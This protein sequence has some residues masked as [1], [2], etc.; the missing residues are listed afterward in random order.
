MLFV[1]QRAAGRGGG[2]RLTVVGRNFGALGTRPVARLGGRSCAATRHWAPPAHCS[3]GALDAARGESGV[4]RG[5]PCYP[6]ACFNNATDAE[7]FEER[8]DCGGFCA[9]CADPQL[10]GP[11]QQGMV[12]CESPP[13]SDTDLDPAQHPEVGP[14]RE[15][16]G[17]SG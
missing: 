1:A 4:D 3:N 15:G 8:A 16:R 9:P 12:V 13:L 7:T 11:P 2:A 10:P 14:P 5:G 17:V 6:E